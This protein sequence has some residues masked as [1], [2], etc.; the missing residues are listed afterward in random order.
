MSA[1]TATVQATVARGA[2]LLAIGACGPRLSTTGSAGTCPNPVLVV[3]NNT[4]RSIEIV[5]YQEGRAP[6]APVLVIAVV[7]PGT[8]TISLRGSTARSYAARALAGGGTLAATDRS[9]GATSV[10]VER[11]CTS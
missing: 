11:R 8:Q 6:G 4:D 7:P 3:H 9:T 1:F 10:T 5:E 2:L